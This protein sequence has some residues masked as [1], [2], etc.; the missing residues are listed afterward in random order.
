MRKLFNLVA[1][2]LQTTSKI[3]GLFFMYEKNIN[4]EKNAKKNTINSD[5]NF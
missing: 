2:Y 1:T 4:K 5:A 3:N